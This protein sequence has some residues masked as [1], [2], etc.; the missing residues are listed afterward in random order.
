[1]RK[2][3]TAKTAAALAV[4]SLAWAG[5]AS[6]ASATP[7]WGKW[8]NAKPGTIKYLYA[9]S[10]TNAST[11]PAVTGMNIWNNY[12][13][14]NSAKIRY[15][16]VSSCSGYAHCVQISESS[17]AHPTSN[18]PS[19]GGTTAAAIVNGYFQ[20]GM[21]IVMYDNGTDAT[22]NCTYSSR[23]T[24]MTHELG[25]ALGLDEDTS[26]ASDLMYP[27]LAMNLSSTRTP[28]VRN[29]TALNNLYK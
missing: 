12:L 29:M 8:Y 2:R 18:P 16:N 26:S 7:T 15:V 24:G 5:P 19:V 20:P 9:S 23:A 13:A 3:T 14:V 4:I 21:K 22:K 27:S 10:T 6:A 28:S 11:W 17:A 25:H 1:M